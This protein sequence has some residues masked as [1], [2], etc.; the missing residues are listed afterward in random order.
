V[1]YAFSGVP[2]PFFNVGILTGQEVNG[3]DLQN[4]ARRACAWAADQGV[5]WLLVVTHEALANGVDAAPELEACGLA[6]LMP[7]YG[8]LA[9]EVPPMAAMPANL[10]LEVPADD[11][12][13]AAIL[14]VNSAAYGMP[15]DAGKPVWG[16]RAFWKD[17]YPVLGRVDGQAACSSVVMMADG[18]RYVALVATTPGL[19][20]RGFADAAM[21]KSLELSAKAHPGTRTF[22]HAT[23]AGRPVYERMGYQTVATHTVFIEKRFLS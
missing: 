12:A 17:H 15:L 22:L 16:T 6:P 23:E 10:A 7:L 13:C 21:R 11:A 14:D 1:E 3:A 4:T 8:M 9:G 18:Y 20:R 19:Q 2:I 5:P